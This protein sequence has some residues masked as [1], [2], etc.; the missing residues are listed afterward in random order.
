[1][2]STEPKTPMAGGCLLSLA[3]MIGVVVGFTQGQASLGFVIGL[4]VGLVL[5]VAIWLVDRRRTH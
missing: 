4:G 2:A 3:I 5:A 1:M